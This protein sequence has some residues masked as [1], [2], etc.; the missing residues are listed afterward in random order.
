MFVRVLFLMLLTITCTAAQ[1]SD[2][3]FLLHK[4]PASLFEKRISFGIVR[5]FYPEATSE[6]CTVALQM[7]IDPVGL[8]RGK[9]AGV[10]LAHYVSDRP[11]AASSFLSVALSEVFG[12]ALAGRSKERPERVDERMPLSAMLPALDCDGG[13]GLIRRV[14][15]PLG[16]TLVIERHPLD[17]RFADWGRSNLYTITVTGRQTVR[18]LLTHLYVLVPVLDNAKHYFVGEDEVEKLL[19]RGEGWL[20]AHPEKELIARRYLRYKRR[21]ADAALA[22]LADIEGV[23]DAD[24][25]ED[26]TPRDAAEQ[27]LEAPVRLNDRRIAAAG[28]AVR[29]LDPPARRVLDLGCGEGRTMEALLRAI[30]GLEQVTGMDVSAFALERAA[31]RLRLD[32]RN[33]RQ[34]PRVSLFQGSLVYRDR[35][36][37][38]YDV[39]LLTEVVEHLDPDRLQSLVR[40]VW[41]NARPR[42]VVVTT[43]NA[44]YNSV[45]SALPA[46]NFRHA[47]HRF[48]WTRAEFAA[49]ADDVAARHGYTV[50]FSGIGDEDPEGRGTPTQMAVFDRTDQGVP[51]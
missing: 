42:R 8:V 17:N 33:E 23:P 14:L 4:N 27:Q 39:A 32:R 11:Y 25:A 45:W 15:E 30:P 2:I 7:E 29:S 34:R 12:T 28:D 43:P 16:Y 48:E 36:L 13:E 44:D 10:A 19:R 22:R 38:G 50:S 35:R 1:A 20:H 37:E 40:V 26:I 31:R 3:G 5:V 41:E 51:V 6:R 24:E 47:D 18:D 21:L 46:G 9:R 49:W